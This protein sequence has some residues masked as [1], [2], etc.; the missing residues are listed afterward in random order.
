MNRC[1]IQ[2]SVKVLNF[3][4]FL[5]S[6]I[7]TKIVGRKYQYYKLHLH[8]FFLDRK[9]FNFLDLKELFDLIHIS[10]LFLKQYITTQVKK[11]NLSCVRKIR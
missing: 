5:L 6:V 11:L 3:F 9:K 8:Q 10:T 7:K 1:W 2:T 4:D